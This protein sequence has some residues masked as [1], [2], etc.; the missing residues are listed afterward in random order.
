MAG[1]AWLMVFFARQP[2]L[3]L[4]TAQPLSYGRAVSASR[5]TIQ[6]Y[7]GKLGAM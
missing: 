3:V 7:F 4:R 2:K 5:E 6:N 1:P